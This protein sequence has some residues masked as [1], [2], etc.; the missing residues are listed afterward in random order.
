MRVKPFMT[1]R[2]LKYEAFKLVHIP[3]FLQRWIIND[4][5]PECDK[6]YMRDF[7]VTEWNCNSFFLKRDGGKIPE[8]F[9]P[10][11]DQNN[12]EARRPE[13][14]YEDLLKLSNRPLVCNV[15]FFECPICFTDIDPGD[16]A[17]LRGC[18]HSFC[19]ECLVNT[20]KFSEEITIKCPFVSDDFNCEFAL[21]EREIKSLLSTDL[22]EKHLEKSIR[23]AQNTI[24]NAFFCRTPNCK[25]W[26]IFEDDINEFACPICNGKN[27]LLC[28]A[29]HPGYNC[30]QHQDIVTGSDTETRAELSRLVSRGEAMHCPKCKVSF[31]T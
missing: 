4:K 5:T 15:D 21:E 13:Q 25:G 23:I 2:E 30:K 8:R 24:E 26:C 20:I 12:N 18:L 16:G 29:I 1:F 19:K 3:M 22:W 7:D 31:I 14:K 17:I 10:V 11:E 28:R 9:R 6:Q 27:C